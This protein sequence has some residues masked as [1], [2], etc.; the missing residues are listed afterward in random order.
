[1]SVFDGVPEDLLAFFTQH[2]K[3]MIDT[4]FEAV[5]K[6]VSGEALAASD[7]QEQLLRVNSG[8]QRPST[9]FEVAWARFNA[10]KAALVNR[11]QLH[12]RIAE[13]EMAVTEAHK[14]SI[15]VDINAKVKY[16][17]LLEEKQAVHE[18]VQG[19]R[20]ELAYVTGLYETTHDYHQAAI[21]HSALHEK[22]RDHEV[23]TLLA[24][25]DKAY[26]K[27]RR[28]ELDQGIPYT[29]PDR[30]TRMDPK[31]IPVVAHEAM[32]PA[33]PNTTAW[34]CQACDRSLEFCTCAN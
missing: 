9:G 30:F 21:A 4:H 12:A 23:K 20:D 1:M 3:D 11:K 34:R 8:E 28:Y 22:D 2:E 27:I 10:L 5:Q 6:L 17:R 19:L 7:K 31:E 26:A 18:T 33:A 29:Q 25:L 24:E 13:L 16:Q 32:P 14:E 15:R